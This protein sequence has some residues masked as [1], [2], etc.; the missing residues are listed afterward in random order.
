M[1]CGEEGQ[2]QRDWR[3]TQCG[4]HVALL[5]D[6]AGEAAGALKHQSGCLF[7]PPFILMLSGSPWLTLTSEQRR[8]KGEAR[9]KEKKSKTFS[10]WSTAGDISTAATA[11]SPSHSFRSCARRLV[12]RKMLLLLLLMLLVCDAGSR[13]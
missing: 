11:S 10:V 12:S 4:A 7:C 3:E 9:K 8:P 5:G 1:Q 13:H 6:V 2:Q